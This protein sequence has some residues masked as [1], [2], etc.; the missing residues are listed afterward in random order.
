MRS[1]Q[2]EL[3]VLRTAVIGFLGEFMPGETL[4][5]LLRGQ[6]LNL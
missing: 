2:Y 5:K 4:I 6:I 1:K 3:R